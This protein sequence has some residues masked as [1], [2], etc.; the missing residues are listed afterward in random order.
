MKRSFLGDPRGKEPS[1]QCRRLKR[2][3]FHPWIEKLPWSRPYNPFQ[4]SHRE[5]LMNRGT[6]WATVHRVTK[7]QTH[8]KQLSIYAHM[9]KVDI[10]I[11]VSLSN[12][13]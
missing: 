8:L 7:S 4:Y 3:G 12:G 6:W 2:D 11:L 10:S 9:K 13:T 5:N 1:C